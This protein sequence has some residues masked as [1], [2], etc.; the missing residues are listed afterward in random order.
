MRMVSAVSTGP[1]T[2]ALTVM[3][4]GPSSVAMTRVSEISPPFDAP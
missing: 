2:M 1:V 4:R 3:P